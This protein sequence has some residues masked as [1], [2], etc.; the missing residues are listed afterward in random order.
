[1]MTSSYQVSKLRMY[2][3]PL[4]NMVYATILISYCQR[5]G[6]M[7]SGF[8]TSPFAL[9]FAISAISWYKETYLY[10][11]LA[12]LCSMGVAF[13]V[14]LIKRVVLSLFEY[15]GRRSWHVQADA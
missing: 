13:V 11:I 4:F 9:W 15:R 5:E 6:L 1:M 3:I 8:R 2:G 7:V 10:L 12:E 14:C